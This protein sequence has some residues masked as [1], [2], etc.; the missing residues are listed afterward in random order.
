MNEILFLKQKIVRSIYLSDISVT[1]CW[2]I[3]LILFNSSGDRTFIKRLKVILLELSKTVPYLHL[4]QIRYHSNALK[5][6]MPIHSLTLQIQK[7][8]DLLLW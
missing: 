1:D 2:S 5:F 8:A 6:S 3:L 4:V 7:L